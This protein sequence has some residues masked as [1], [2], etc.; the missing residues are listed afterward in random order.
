MNHSEMIRNLRAEIAKLQQVLDLVL[1]HSSDAQEVRR[2]GRPKAAGNRET[3]VKP[4]GSSPKKRTMSAEG[5]ARI[6]AAQKKR[7]AAQKASATDRTFAK[8]AIFAKRLSKTVSPK[9][10]RK[11]TP[12][13]AKKSTDAG[14]RGGSTQGIAQSLSTKRSASVTA[15]KTAMKKVAKKASQPVTKQQVPGRVEVQTAA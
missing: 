14:K 4:Q 12:A 9:S 10:A 2:P 7:W 13:T 1:E 3:R 15:G 6:A 11:P 8:K 5:K